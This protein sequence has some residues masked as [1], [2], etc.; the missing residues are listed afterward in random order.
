[1]RKEGVNATGAVS[2]S[3][4][5]L[6]ICEMGGWIKWVVSGATDVADNQLL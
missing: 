3:D 1:M 5:G 2:S 6:P 4:L